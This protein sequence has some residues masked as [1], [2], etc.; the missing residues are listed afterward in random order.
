MTHKLGSTPRNKKITRS[1]TVKN[2]LK[3]SFAVGAVLVA[4]SANSQAQTV[5]VNGLGSSAIFLELGLAASSATT[6][7]PA[8]LGAT[9]LWTENVNSVVA[10][11][12]SATGSLQDKGNA[13]VAWTPGTGT[14]SAPVSP[15]I[16]AYLQTDSVVGNRCLFNGTLCKIAYPTSNPATNNLILTT[17][18][19]SLPASIANALN[20]SSVNV[21]GT[22]I[23]PEDAEFAIARALKPCGTAVA[24]GSQYL[25]LGYTNGTTINSF[26]STS[27]FNVI[28]FTLPTAY[29]VTPI[30]AVPVVVVVNSPSASTG[31]NAAGITNLTS[32][33][34]AKFLDG[35][36]SYTNQALST[37]AATG[38]A[39]TTIIREPLSGTYNTMEYNVPNNTTLKTSQDVGLN[40][41]AAQKDCSGTSAS[42]NPMNIATTSGGARQRAIGTGQELSS[43]LATPTSLGYGFWSVANFKAFTGT[44]NAR[45]LTVD[46]VDPLLNTSS[47]SGIT[48]ST[49]NGALPLAGSA[50]M[51]NVNLLNVA[52]GTYPIWSMVRLVN[53]G[54]TAPAAVTNLANASQNFVQS[55][56]S[57]ARPD[58]VQTSSLSVVHS[59]VVPPAGAGEPTSAANGHVGLPTSVCT[60]TELGGDVGGTVLTLV[61]DST[62]CSRNGV[63]TGQTGLRK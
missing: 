39:V 21:A 49:Y 16:Y 40:Q 60:A 52:N 27:T 48:Y 59:H 30:G 12:T 2:L 14:C 25:G 50:E 63:K 51:A 53:A 22:D 36:Y 10:T 4:L 34:L 56:S 37:P 45:Y 46:G 15:T 1:N 11:D 13:F 54:S 3:A 6:A 18:E 24:T 7:T 55:G 9:C 5:A 58:F 61:A 20:S 28:N 44:T 42:P 26:F 47:T 8:G 23:R 38:L 35:T 33:A 29:T 19:V 41:P 17:G 32:S 62:Y 43:V 57:T 31:F